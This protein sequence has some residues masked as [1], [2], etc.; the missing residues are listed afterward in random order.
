[1]MSRRLQELARRQYEPALRPSVIPISGVQLKST[2]LPADALVALLSAFCELPIA[3]GEGSV[4][5]VI[6][7]TLARIA[8]S[9]R[10]G[11]LYPALVASSGSGGEVSETAWRV[12]TAIRTADHIRVSPSVV[13][14]AGVRLFEDA[15]S[16][17]II[18]A[19]E[20][21]GVTLHVAQE[22]LDFFDGEKE[23]GELLQYAARALGRG[24]LVARR[25]Q[26]A[27]SA[28]AELSEASARLVQAEKLASLGQLAAGV[29]HELNNPLTSIVAYTDM[30]L[31]KFDVD[32]ADAEVVS[33]L[34]RIRTAAAE[35]TRFSRE[36]VNYAR[37]SAKAPKLPVVIADVIQTA[38][39]FCLH[40]FDESGLQFEFAEPNSTLRVLGRPEQLTQ[41]FVNLFVN[42]VHAQHASS[43][44]QLR[45]HIAAIDDWI[46]IQVTDAG[47]GVAED[48][49]ERIF[50]TFFTTKETG[51]GTGLGLAIVRSIIEEHGGVVELAARPAFA[52]ELSPP[53]PATLQPAT[54]PPAQLQP[55]V[56]APLSGATFVVRIPAAS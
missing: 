15:P 25:H 12:L 10:L 34:G 49:R 38:K 21:A 6:L 54:L 30:L 1:M 16:E 37:P 46:E 14:G 42:A 18:E 28:A 8:P 40:L 24:I 33:R 45:V 5:R 17:L 9:A 35:L 29:V 39:S 56:Q 36:L 31:K 27:L 50:E 55:P 26:A 43:A 3:D 47:P 44:S 52:P 7:E 51:T 11:I 2:T 53:Q 4:V 22:G 13:A 23:Y 48:A 41:V 32:G 19:A 20:V